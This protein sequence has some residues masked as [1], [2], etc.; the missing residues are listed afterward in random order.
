MLADRNA[1]ARC[2]YLFLGVKQVLT[3]STIKWSS[4]SY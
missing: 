1:Q 3:E 4:F 2:F